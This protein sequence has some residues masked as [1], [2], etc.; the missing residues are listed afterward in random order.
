MLRQLINGNSDLIVKA[1]ALGLLQLTLYRSG[2][3][4]EAAEISGSN[5]PKAFSQ[6]EAQMKVLSALCQ[7]HMPPTTS[8]PLGVGFQDLSPVEEDKYL[9]ERSKITLEPTIRDGTGGSV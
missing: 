4:K 9:F 1:V 6:L 3:L 8:L 7:G 2:R 5:L